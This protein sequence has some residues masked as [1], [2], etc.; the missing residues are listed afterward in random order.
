MYG[1]VPA[2]RPG[3]VW[4]LVRAPLAGDRRGPG[5]GTEPREAEVEQLRAARGEH[6]VARLQVAMNDTLRMRNGERLGDLDGRT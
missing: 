2:M 3:A 6:D 5:G 4:L 1:S